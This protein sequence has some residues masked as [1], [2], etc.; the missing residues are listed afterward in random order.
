MKKSS[1]EDNFQI[2]QLLIFLYFQVDYII[3]DYA[4]FLF[5]EAEQNS[6]ELAFKEK[7]LAWKIK[8]R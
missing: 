7:I 8:T 1:G 5:E 6:L 3:T 2:K 4:L